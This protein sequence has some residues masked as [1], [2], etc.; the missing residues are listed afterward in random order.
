MSSTVPRLPAPQRRQALID[1]ALR[2]FSAGSYRGV[3]TAEIAREAGV[4]EPILYRHFASKRDLYLACIEEAWHRL[5]A[6]WEQILAE[7]EPDGWLSA[8]GRSFME[9][10]QAKVALSNLWVQAL[11]EASED[12][13]IRAALRDH[14]RE[15]HRFLADVIRRSQADGVVVPERDPTAEAWIFIAVGL[16]GSVGRRLGGLAKEDFPRI[17]ASRRE[18]MTQRKA[19][20]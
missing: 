16:L 9:L 10:Q 20:E 2:V 17:I 4:S 6:L 14:L 1:T 8:M 5:R 13:V 18:W 19:Y 15:V 12:P 3:T 11:T 7:Q